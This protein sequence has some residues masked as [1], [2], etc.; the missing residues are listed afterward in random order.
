M[1]DHGL[2]DGDHEVIRVYPEGLSSG[3]ITW[4]FHANLEMAVKLGVITKQIGHT[5][6]I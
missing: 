6:V 2:W 1:I 3:S 4:P 5:V